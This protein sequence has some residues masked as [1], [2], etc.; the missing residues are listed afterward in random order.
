MFVRRKHI[1]VSCRAN[2]NRSFILEQVLLKLFEEERLPVDIN[3]GGVM[4][5]KGLI[6][7][8]YYPRGVIEFVLALQETGL[9]FVIPRIRLHQ[10]HAFTIED[11]QGADLIMTMT[12][13]QRDHLRN[14]ASPTTRVIM[15][16]QLGDMQREV[17]VYDAMQEPDVTVEAFIR[18]IRQ[19]Q[20]YIDMEALKALL[21][22]V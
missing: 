19:L 5:A 14:Y 13:R 3:S 20:D 17:D 4:L 22:L 16:S 15:L 7:M 6:N 21:G 9:D 2:V 8:T 18:Q 10:A 12:K 1:Y 11:I